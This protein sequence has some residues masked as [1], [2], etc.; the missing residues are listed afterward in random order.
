MTQEFELPNVLIADDHPL[1]RSAL[2]TVLDLVSP[3]FRTLE[4]EALQQA[5]DM[6]RG[7]ADI[8]LLLLDL[9]MPG[10]RGVCDELRSD[11]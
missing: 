5:V 6:L 11:G 4:A 7:D 3:Q 1:Y 9:N 8:E 2:K 10:S